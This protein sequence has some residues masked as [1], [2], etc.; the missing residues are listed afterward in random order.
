MSEAT[1]T[2]S[3]QEDDLPIV[4]IFDVLETDTS[5]AENGKWFK[6]EDLFPRGAGMRFKLRRMTSKAAQVAYRDILEK[7][8]KFQN[9]KGEFPTE[10]DQKIL[11]EHLSKAIIVDWDGVYGKDKDKLEFTPE[12]AFMLCQALP[13]FRATVYRVSLDM[14]KF[15]AASQEAIEKN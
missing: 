14:D 7:Y 9:A 4:S 6:G 10:I 2:V 3:T 13:D 1:N 8:A 12:A 11:S 15:R 5:G